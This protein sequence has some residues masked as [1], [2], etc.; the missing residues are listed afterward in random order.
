VRPRKALEISDTQEV[1][2]ESNLQQI[3]NDLANGKLKLPRVQVS[4]DRVTGLRAMVNKSGLISLHAAYTIGASRPLVK[5]GELDPKSP[6]HLTIE[7][8]REVTKTIQALARKGID[9]Q[10]GLHRSM[11]RGIRKEGVKWRPR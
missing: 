4:D 10:E 1:F 8:A 7:E 3:A 9:V 6:E 11:I 2:T 5:I